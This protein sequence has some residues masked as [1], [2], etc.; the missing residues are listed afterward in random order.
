MDKFV[1]VKEYNECMANFEHNF[2]VT[3]HLIELLDR[4]LTTLEQPKTIL[5]SGA[6]MVRPNPTIKISLND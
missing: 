2:N 5:P 6:E 3:K 1:K 4:R